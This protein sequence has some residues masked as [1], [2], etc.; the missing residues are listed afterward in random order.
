[1]RSVKWLVAAWVVMA[2]LTAGSWVWAAR[3]SPQVQTCRAQV[4]ALQ[5][6]VNV[7]Y[8][9]LTANPSYGLDYLLRLKAQPLRG[10]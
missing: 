8:E 6:R 7:L 9:Y 3:T 5:Q 1:M 2:L 10:C 4:V